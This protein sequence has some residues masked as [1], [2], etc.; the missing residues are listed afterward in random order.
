MPM[1]ERNG[2]LAEGDLSKN[3]ACE[4]D[5]RFEQTN[6]RSH[7]WVVGLMAN[8]AE[9]TSSGKF[10]AIRIIL[11]VNTVFLPLSPRIN[12]RRASLLRETAD[13]VARSF[14][15][16]ENEEGVYALRRS[17]TSIKEPLL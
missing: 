11:S 4:H 16:R 13:H 6:E 10:E 3:N 7:S 1:I 5:T 17:T 2:R 15:L 9:T 12:S 8:A 14:G